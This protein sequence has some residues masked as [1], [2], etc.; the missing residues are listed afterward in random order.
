[1]DDHR[2]GTFSITL[3][4]VDDDSESDSLLPSRPILGKKIG[5]LTIIN[6]DALNILG[7]RIARDTVLSDSVIYRRRKGRWFDPE[8]YK[9][10]ILI[11]EMY[12]AITSNLILGGK[13]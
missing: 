8:N 5:D 2:I 9:I 3:N 4:F 1:M 10:Q 6:V 7:M 11:E 13:K 12:Q